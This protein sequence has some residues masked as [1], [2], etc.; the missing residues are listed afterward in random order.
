[1]I[2]LTWISA[3]IESVCQSCDQQ[4]ISMKRGVILFEV[5]LQ[6]K[7]DGYPYITGTFL[8]VRHFI[9]LEKSPLA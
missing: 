9:L 4:K 1:M 2:I 7:L 5:I 6:K 8:C 3:F